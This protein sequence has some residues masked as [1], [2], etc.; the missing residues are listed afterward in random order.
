MQHMLDTAGTWALVDEIAVKVAGRVL[1]QRD[2]EAVVLAQWA[3]HRNFWMR[4]SCLLAH[5]EL[6]RGGDGTH[7]ERFAAFA[8]PML[9][10]KEFFI[11]KVRDAFGVV[12]ILLMATR[13]AIGWVLRDTSRKLPALVNAFALQHARRLS[14]VTHREAVKKLT[15]AQKS[16]IAAL[17]Q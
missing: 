6:M 4:R 17:R 12:A 5:L 2:D 15:A 1:A 13:Q 11:Q 3:A 7:F 9:D 14:T 10:E 16:A 8:E